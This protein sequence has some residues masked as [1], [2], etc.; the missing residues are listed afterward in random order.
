[1]IYTSSKFPQKK[2]MISIM[3]TVR[4]RLPVYA[5]FMILSVFLISANHFMVAKAETTP[6]MYVDPAVKAATINEIFT[7]DI[8]VANVS[9]LCSWQVYIYYLNDVLEA[10]G[11]EEGPFLMSHGP[12]LF[13]GSFNNNYNSSHGELWMYCLRTWSGTGVN[14]NGVLGTVTFKAKT[15]GSSPLPLEQTILGNSTAQRITHTTKNGTVNVGS[16]DIAVVSVLPLKT[17]VGQ[18][19]RMR[20]N[21]TVANHGSQ[22]ETFNMTIYANGTGVKTLTS[23]VTNGTSTTLTFAWN[24]TGFI[25]GNYSIN[26]TAPQVLYETNL[27]DNTLLDG[28]VY[29]TIPGNLNGDKV[30]DIYDAITLASAYGSAPGRLSWNSNADINDDDVIDIYDAIILAGH[31]GE[32][33]P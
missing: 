5:L 8:D 7:L 20:I 16:H 1:M 23:T 9:D 22:T 14:G 21:G 26:G 12:T 32:S 17:I 25:K 6:A 27:T 13:D 11:Y 29:V 30:V 3:G 31:Y 28:Y 33:M 18:G 2:R 19:F 10:N 4:R 24:T 15:G